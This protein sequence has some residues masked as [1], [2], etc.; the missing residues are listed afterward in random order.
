MNQFLG[1][2]RNALKLDL[3]R[4]NLRH[5]ENVIQEQQQHIAGIDHDRQH[6]ALLVLQ[7]GLH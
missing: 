7:L 4:F 2:E 5:I 3:A 1:G 6:L